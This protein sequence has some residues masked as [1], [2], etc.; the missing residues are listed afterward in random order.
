MIR[1]V[2]IVQSNPTD[3]QKLSEL[4]SACGCETIAANDGEELLEIAVQCD[5]MLIDSRMLDIRRK[6]FVE[7][8]RSRAPGV[9]LVLTIGANGDVQDY[10]AMVSVDAWDFI[11]RPYCEEAVSL[12]LHRISEQKTLVEQNKYLW[13]E[14]EQIQGGVE[15]VS[16]DQRMMDII[17]QAGKVAAADVSV[18][19]LGETGTEKQTVA[20]LI[21]RSS[22]R[23]TGPFIH[24]DCSQKEAHLERMLMPQSPDN[25][26]IIAGGGTIFFDEITRL[27]AE[28]QAMVLRML[29]D[30][31]DARIV[32]SSSDDPYEAIERKRFR[33][34][35]FFRINEAQIFLPPLRERSGDIPLLA[36]S[37]INRL[38]L[39]PP[40]DGWEQLT[41]YDWP[42]NVDEL[43]AAVRLAAL[44]REWSS[45]IADTLLPQRRFTKLRKRRL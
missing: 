10:A 38:G 45:N 44:R 18:M 31:P 27:P 17:R 33:E 20:R 7:T 14:I 43:E 4:L 22:A 24:V 8:L 16:Q 34:D 11:N 13:A 36:A 35:L 29:E 23:H 37:F 19:I 5:A 12:L 21:H 28:L 15:V 41:E 39:E 2:A 42:G 9:P 40:A 32:C 30:G 3:R 1:K 26:S 25:A 6:E